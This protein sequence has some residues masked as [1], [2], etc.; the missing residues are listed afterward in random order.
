MIGVHK[1]ILRIVSQLLH[2]A[3]RKRFLTIGFLRMLDSQ[4][5]DLG[6]RLLGLYGIIISVVLNFVFRR[7]LVFTRFGQNLPELPSW[8]LFV[9]QEEW[10]DMVNYCSIERD[11]I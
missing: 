11:V 10:S 4:L 1:T 6:R 7:D 2:T 5:E 9:L 8:C 3:A